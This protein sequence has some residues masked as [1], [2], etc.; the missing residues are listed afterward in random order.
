L[1]FA[2]PSEIKMQRPSLEGRSSLVVE[3]EPL[4]VMEI[5]QAFDANWGR[6]DDDERAEACPDSCGA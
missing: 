6:A 3:D 5:A 2:A 4:I 1:R